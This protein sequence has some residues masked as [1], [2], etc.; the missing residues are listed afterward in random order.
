[1]I[2]LIPHKTIRGEEPSVFFFFQCKGIHGVAFR[3][4]INGIDRNDIIGSV[5]F[6][7]AAAEKSENR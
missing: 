7:S 4:V 3:A 2:L 6:I 1:M 5:F